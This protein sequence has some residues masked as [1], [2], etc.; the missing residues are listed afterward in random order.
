MSRRS[1]KIKTV[2]NPSSDPSPSLELE[3]PLQTRSGRRLLSQPVA[4]T[5]AAQQTPQSRRRPA[6]KSQRLH[7]EEVED[8]TSKDSETLPQTTEEATSPAKKESRSQGSAEA[9]DEAVEPKPIDRSGEAHRAVNEETDCPVKEDKKEESTGPQKQDGGES[10]RIKMEKDEA[11]AARE[12]EQVRLTNGKPVTNNQVP[13]PLGKPKSG[14]VWKDRTKK[15][16]SS[17]LK[18]KSLCT[19]WEKKMQEKQE[20]KMMKH[21]ARQLQEDKA[22][23]KEAKRLRREENLKRKAEN[24]L[25]SEIVQVIHNP[26]K[27]KRMKKKQLRQIE[28]RDTLALMQKKKNEPKSRKPHKKTK[29]EDGAQEA[30]K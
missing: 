16:F 28:K 22:K 20:K 13:I 14:R 11:K 10:K 1:V 27:I 7:S 19:S 26:A 15:R 30:V 17:M 21:F 18:S 6:R 23:E 29:A 2:E 3:E 9:E 5:E 12:K 24:E 25:K 8:T 4:V